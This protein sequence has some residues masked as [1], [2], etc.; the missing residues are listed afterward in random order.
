[1]SLRVIIDLTMLS[2][3]TAAAKYNQ[4]VLDTLL[5]PQPVKLVQRLLMI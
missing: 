3:A 1:M 2:H 5:P 4:V